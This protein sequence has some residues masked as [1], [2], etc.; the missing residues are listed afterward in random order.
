M[1]GQ[2]IV[3][4]TNK[5]LIDSIRAQLWLTVPLA[6][7]AMPALG[8]QADDFAYELSVSGGSSDNIMR[9]AENKQDETIA[10]LG[11][12]FSLDKRTS[13]LSAEVVSDL[14]YNDYLQGDIDSELLGT[15]VGNAGVTLIEDRLRWFIRDSFGQVLGDPFLPSAPDNRDNLN[16][17]STGLTATF[18]FGSQTRLDLQGSYSDTTYED[19]DLDS[20]TALVEAGLVHN[21]SSESAFGVHLRAAQ[22]A[23]VQ[24][25]ESD[26]DVQEGLVS[27]SMTGSRTE[28]EAELGY[29]KLELDNGSE[30][31]GPIVRL[32]VSRGI[33]AH[34][35]LLFAGGQE[36][37]N[38]A[39]AFNSY[40]Q[41]RPAGLDSYGGQQT[42]DPFTNRYA[43]LTWDV[44]GARTQAALTARWEE[45]DY[46]SLSDLNEEISMLTLGVRRDLSAALNAQ[47]RADY[48]RGEFDGR[49]GDYKE[50]RLAMELRWQFARTLAM[51]FSYEHGARDDNTAGTEYRENR[52]W[53]T[54]AY[55]HGSP[56]SSLSDREFS[57]DDR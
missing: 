21:L 20:N 37:S 29:A 2:V 23:Y 6:G 19:L 14:A 46:G 42:A 17:L 45:Q 7:L 27:Y 15:V 41:G 53:L 33:S 11:L 9:D 28:I 18:A 50:M 40:S 26:Y 51:S 35:T 52:F 47:F 36:F 8:Q 5:K 44:Q 3:K 39:E 54:F 16:Y 56:Q 32:S 4:Q 12:K 30:D 48:A 49:E 55:N 43:G 1:A 24:A 25:T 38:S 22:V 31:D 10:A 57:G 34:S 13:R